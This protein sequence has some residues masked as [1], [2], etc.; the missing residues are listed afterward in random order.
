[1]KRYNIKIGNNGYTVE[2]KSVENGFARVN[3][4]GK[5]IEVAIEKE[6]VAAPARKEAAASSP[7]AI[8]T[9]APAMNTNGQCITSPLPGT[10]ISILVK[11]GD[12][13]KYGQK[14]AVLEAMKMENEILSDRNGTVTKVYVTKGDTVPEGGQIAKIN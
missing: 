4:N 2:V 6:I 1:M 14:I 10:I 13:V 5:D 7:A 8:E 12:A 9:A 3:V 11:E